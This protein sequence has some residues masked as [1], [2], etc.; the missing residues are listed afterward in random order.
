MSLK[1]EP[2][3]TSKNGRRYRALME[4][5]II[6]K[7]GLV[8]FSGSSGAGKT[9]IINS[10]LLN[11]I[12]YGKS[13]ELLPSG[14]QPRGFFDAIFLLIGSQDD[15]YDHLIREDIIKKNHVAVN[16]TPTDLQRIID[17][18]KAWIEQYKGN[19]KKVP[20]VLIILDDVVADMKFMKSKPMLNLAT[21]QRHL[22]CTTFL[23]TQYLNLVPKSIRQQALWNFICKVNRVE[24]ELITETFCPPLVSS[25]TFRSI[26]YQTL[27]DTEHSKHNILIISKK[28]PEETRFRRNLDEYIIMPHVSNLKHAI[29]KKEI[30][31]IVD[32]VDLKE[33]NKSDSDEEPIELKEFNPDGKG[34]NEVNLKTIAETPKAVKKKPSYSKYLKR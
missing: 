11:P 18:Q 27:L 13:T 6:P 2:L 17:S 28:E 32:D 31:E 7:E 12:M 5:G 8:I 24:L 10:M 23:C 26:V 16:P 34:I 3:Q 33:I 20:N 25:K 1:I 19:I 9:T 4:K 22:N 15:A 14:S 21:A 29:K 30:V